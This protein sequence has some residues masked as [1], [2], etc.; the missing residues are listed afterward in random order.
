MKVFETTTAFDE[1]YRVNY[2]GAF[3]EFRCYRG[4]T[5]NRIY[6]KPSEVAESLSNL[7][8]YDASSLDDESTERLLTALEDNSG[9]DQ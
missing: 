3:M 7:V 2:N 6:M 5:N 9:E 8:E 4:D 1:T